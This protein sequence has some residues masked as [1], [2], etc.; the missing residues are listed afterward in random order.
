MTPSPACYALIKRFEGYAKLLPD[1]RC[2]AY[3]DP[4]TGGAPW[5]IGY[6]ST[7]PDI[8]EG[9]IWTRAEAEERLERDVNKFAASIN[10]LIG[11]DP[12]T[13]N[14]FDALVCFSYNVGFSALAKST[15]L[16]LHMKGDKA[17]AAEQ[18]KRWNRA[19]GKEM[20]GLLRRRLAE[21]DL[22]RGA[23]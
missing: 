16:S 11:N 15:L 2:E 6:G 5:T 19:G 13:Q 20:P 12:T 7:G 21:A 17:G 14:E 9:T 18:F 8:H 4:A 1:G 3:P 22:Y 23:A 10:A